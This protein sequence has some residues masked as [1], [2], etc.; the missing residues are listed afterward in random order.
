ME[1]KS[2]FLLDPCLDELMWHVEHQ[3]SGPW[4]W[5]SWK[6]MW[7]HLCPSAWANLTSIVLSWTIV[8]RCY[9][10]SMRETQGSFYKRCP[11]QTARCHHQK[12]QMWP[13]GTPHILSF[14]LSWRCMFCF[15]ETWIWIY[16]PW[17]IVMYIFT[18][19][20]ENELSWLLC[21]TLD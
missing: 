17:M 19:S 12:G 10:P 20:G 9:Q 2:S 5:W 16:M 6:G 14:P 4:I 1:M 18:H 11:T 3:M 15:S 8:Y 13:R 7:A 21:L